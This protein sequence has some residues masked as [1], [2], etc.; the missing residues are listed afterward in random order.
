MIKLPADVFAR[1][2][3][4]YQGRGVCVTGGTGFIGSH[5][6]DA[7]VSVGARI[8]VIDDLSNSQPDLLAD[9][10]ELEPQRIRFVHGSILDDDALD[11]AMQ[12]CDLVIHL[13]AMGS[14]P[15][16]I[17]EP[18]RSASINATGTLRVLQAARRH[19]IRR[20][21]FS[22]SSSVYGDGG[23][24][25]PSADALLAPKLESQLPAPLSPYAASKLSAEAYVRAWAH[26][27]NLSA[28]SLRLFNVFGPRQAAD[29]AY[30][31][32]LPAWCKALAHGKPPV[33]YGDGQQS[34]DFTPVANVV[35]A[36]LLAGS[37]GREL[38]GEAV[39]VALGQR[40]PL[41]EFCQMVIQ[42]YGTPQ[43][44]PEFQVPRLSDLRHSLADIS[45]AKQLFDYAPIT[46]LAEAVAEAVGHYRQSL[47]P[48]KA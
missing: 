46:P 3:G 36:L 19:G 14:V 47:A 23:Q 32:V 6:V 16:S 8:S 35:Y 41:I 28:V 20:V 43:V 12:G 2:T 5:L 11:Q 38:R 10:I 17:I 30:A 7:L 31:A 18:Q 40:T 29:S 42:A 4:L 48:T 25:N 44:Q 27:Y 15:R 22:S 26:T 33:I 45:L 37:T 9:L 34:R 24:K 1:L 13:A 21:V 39:N